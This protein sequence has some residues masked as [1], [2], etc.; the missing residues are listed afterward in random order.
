[1]IENFLYIAFIYFFVV[2]SLSFLVLF[3]C[4]IDDDGIDGIKETFDMFTDKDFYLT[5]VIP[6]FIKYSIIF[7]FCYLI[8]FVIKLVANK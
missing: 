7:I 3:A 8:V 5:V 6:T 2:L 4:N 1:M